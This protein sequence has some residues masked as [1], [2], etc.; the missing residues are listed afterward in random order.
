M[1]Y[2]LH[3]YNIGFRK[4]AVPIV[5]ALIGTGLNFAFTFSCHM[6]DSESIHSAGFMR[7]YGLWTIQGNW[8]IYLDGKLFPVSSKA[9]TAVSATNSAGAT[10]LEV[11]SP[12]RALGVPVHP[13]RC[14]TWVQF[15]AKNLREL[16][17]TQI[18]AAG[19]ISFAA[20]VISVA[21]TSVFL[22]LTCTSFRNIRRGYRAM[23]VL[24]LLESVLCGAS[25]VSR[26]GR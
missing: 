7:G 15:G 24:A 10:S 11:E 18:H 1:I 14:Y 19:A 6:F 13:N 23:G 16:L 4:T 21:T 9:A 22:V 17:G 12:V 25:L 8:P 26:P 2:I 5:L 20:C 3:S